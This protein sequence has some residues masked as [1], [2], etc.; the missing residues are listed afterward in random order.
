M[1]SALWLPL[2]DELADP[3]AVAHL[4][5]EAEETGWHGMFVWDHLRWRAPVRQAG[6]PLVAL[7]AVATATEQ[8]RLGPMVLP[9][10][11]RRPA[12]VARETAALD[13][14]SSGRL[15]LGVGIGSDRFAH[16]LSKTGEQLDDR[17]RGEMLDEAL[18][19]LTDAWTGEPVHHHGEHYTVDDFEFLPRPVQQPGIPVWIAG[20]AG[21]VRPMRRAA[22]HDGFFPVNLEH[23][24]QLAEAVAAVTDLRQ[25]RTTPFDVVA[26]LPVDADPTPYAAVGATWWLPELDPDAVT[27][28]QVK[29]L[30]RDG[31]LAV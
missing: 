19:V 11:R 12:K 13:L 1:K 16:E 17:I 23:P 8:L 15:T 14:L 21:R 22:R 4:A 10:P 24:D 27:L 20:F 5:A 3:R 9:L 30:L 2:F 26:S 7:A 6:D 29:G 31:P 18:A 25:G 28:D